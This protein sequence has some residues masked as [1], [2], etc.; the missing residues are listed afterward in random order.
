MF[1]PFDSCRQ[2]QSQFTTDGRQYVLMSSP[3]FVNC[4]TVTVLS[5]SGALS[6]ERSG[7]SFVSPSLKS[8]SICTWIIYSLQVLQVDSWLSGRPFLIRC[9]PAGRGLMEVGATGRNA[10]WLADRS[11]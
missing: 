3:M 6:D 9:Q 5:Y 4:L 7:L 2:S 1:R 10:D 8:L 11:L